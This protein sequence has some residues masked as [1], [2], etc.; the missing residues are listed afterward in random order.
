MDRWRGSEG[1]ESLAEVG[2]NA[3]GGG[4]GTAKNSPGRHRVVPKTISAAER[5]TPSLGVVRSP[6]RTQGNCWCQR[7][8]TQRARS[9][10]FKE[11]WKRSTIPLDSGW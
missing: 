10:F 3:A 1:V 6:R 8:P 5:P 9:V 11:R 2:K 7:L 4:S